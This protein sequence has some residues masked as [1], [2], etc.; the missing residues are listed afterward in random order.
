MQK[1]VNTLEI[2]IQ[3]LFPSLLEVNSL[4][5]KP[6]AVQNTFIT[7]SFIVEN[8]KII[9][10]NAEF[11]EN[12]TNLLQLHQA[13]KTFITRKVNSRLGLGKFGFFLQNLVIS[14]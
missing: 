13:E 14:I 11:Y 9:T 12:L 8:I 2:Y 1:R 6:R 10:E 4:Q 5:F 7:Q 3:R